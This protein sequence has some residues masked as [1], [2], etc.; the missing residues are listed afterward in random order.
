MTEMTIS[1][2][3]KPSLVVFRKVSFGMAK[4]LHN[5]CKISQEG[6]QL[7]D[8]NRW[9][10]DLWGRFIVPCKRYANL[11]PPPGF[12]FTSEGEGLLNALNAEIGRGNSAAVQ[13]AWREAQTKTANSIA[14]SPGE[15]E[16]T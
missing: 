9:V 1:S 16:H 11:V 13:A 12:S 2:D 7:A 5:A 10:G 4:A 14:I 8:T 3:S 6:R 15:V